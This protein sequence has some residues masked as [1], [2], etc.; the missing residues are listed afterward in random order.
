MEEAK[1]SK[2]GARAHTGSKILGVIQILLLLCLSPES[3]ADGLS[4][5]MSRVGQNMF[6]VLAAIAT[7]NLEYLIISMVHLITINFIGICALA[8]ALIAFSH[9]KNKGAK[10][11]VVSCIILIVVGFLLVLGSA[12]PFC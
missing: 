9:Y 3:L 6:I 10:S 5:F 2:I 8:Q 4:V 7:F 11:T 1:S 12:V